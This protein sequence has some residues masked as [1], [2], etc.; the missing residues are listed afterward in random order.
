MVLFLST[1]SQVVGTGSDDISGFSWDEGTAGVSNES[2]VIWVSGPS[3]VT[4]ITVIGTSIWVSSISVS[5]ISVVGTSI[6]VPQTVSSSIKT[7]SIGKSLSGKVSCFS[8]LDLKGLGW[9]NCT[10]GVPM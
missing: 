4:G 7:S 2:W 8:C 1:G 3:G 9:G 6:A 10:V 5:S